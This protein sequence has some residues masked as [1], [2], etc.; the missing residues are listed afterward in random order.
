MVRPTFVTP[1][2]ALAPLLFSWHVVWNSG[3]HGVRNLVIDTRFIIV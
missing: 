2:C 3:H 1:G